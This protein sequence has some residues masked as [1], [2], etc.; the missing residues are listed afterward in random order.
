[1]VDINTY[2]KLEWESPSVGLAHAKQ[3]QTPTMCA[4]GSSLHIFQDFQEKLE[5]YIGRPD[6]YVKSDFICFLV[7]LK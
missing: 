6:F 3:Q 7:F 2:G 5:I 1:M 4:E